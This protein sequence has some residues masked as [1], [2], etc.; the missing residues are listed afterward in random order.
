MT[1]PTPHETYT[2]ERQI[3]GCLDHVWAC[4]TDPE[5]KRR[6]FA[7]EGSGTEEYRLDLRVGGTEYGRF[8]MTDGPAPGV[9][10]NRTTYLVIEDRALL[11]TAYT[12]A[13]DGRIHSAS[14]ASIRFAEAE[15]GTRL[16]IEETGV[17][18]ADSDGPEGR[19]HGTGVLLDTLQEMIADGRL[20]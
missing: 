20:S 15:G 10:E 12:M 8:V 5:L 7:A 17:F 14:L 16:S 4:W 13:W 11:V 6:W 1:P 3:A 2:L 19:R 9:H 18:F